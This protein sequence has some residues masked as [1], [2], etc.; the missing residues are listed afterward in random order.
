MVCVSA[1]TVTGAHR[2]TRA[3]EGAAD[4]CDCS[5]AN[6]EVY[7]DCGGGHGTCSAATNKWCVAVRAPGAPGLLEVLSRRAVLASPALAEQRVAAETLAA[8][9][10]AARA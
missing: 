6:C 3:C 4:S 10:S 2:R 8:V 9:W 1:A 5:G 7:N